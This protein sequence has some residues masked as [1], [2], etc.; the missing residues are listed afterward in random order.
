M[1]WLFLCRYNYLDMKPDLL[2]KGDKVAIV[3]PS[4]VIFKEQLVKALEVFSAW[5]LEV[6][7][8]KSLFTQSG[9]F[10]GSDE[11]RLSDFQQMIDDDSIK[12]I[13]CAR[14]GYGITRFLDQLDFTSFVKNPKWVVGF[15]DITAL[16]LKL[17]QVG[18][19]SIHGVMPVQFDYEG[20]EGSIISLYRSLFEE[21]IFY[22]V[23]VSQISIPGEAEAELIG[24]NLSLIADSLSTPSEV[25]TEGRILFIEE[26]DEYLYQIDR[27]L[28]Q[29][30]RAGKLDKL[31][32]V[33]VGDF[34]K[35]KD[36]EIP[37]GKNL[38]SLIIGY[39]KDLNIP[40]VFGFPAGHEPFHLALPFSRV[41]K[42]K[43]DDN[44][45]WVNC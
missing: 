33:I 30:K 27:M 8:G 20:I 42:L 9:Y 35:I 25:N 21:E 45:C 34:S 3:A 2:K 39:F 26:I 1:R 12:A 15:S 44:S 43:V 7:L 13:F 14:G 19:E 6:V 24:G 41:V 11:E 28:T 10:A 22:E 16:H 38:E 36:T 29:L 40:L 4:R 31:K 18:V 17:N 23:P 5:G 37:F 32:G